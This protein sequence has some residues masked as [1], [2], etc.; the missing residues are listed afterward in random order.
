[1]KFNS[2]NDMDLKYIQEI[3]ISKKKLALKI[4]EKINI[5][6]N[7]LPHILKEL[8]ISSDEFKKYISFKE[9]RNF[10]FYYEIINIIKEYNKKI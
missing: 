1:M 6:P 8:Q 3:E 4:L 9:S 7:L 5:E 2:H 10:S